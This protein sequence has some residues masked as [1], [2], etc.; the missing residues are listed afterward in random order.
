MAK[1]RRRQRYY[2]REPTLNRFVSQHAG[3]FM[4]MMISASIAGINFYYEAK[5]AHAQVEELEDKL[6][7]AE[8]KLKMLESRAL[9]NQMRSQPLLQ[10]PPQ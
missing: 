7:E 10:E 6:D 2:H 4:A 9:L 3:F 5:Q 8:D 1:K